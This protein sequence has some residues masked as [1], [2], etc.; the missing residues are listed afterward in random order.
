MKIFAFAGS[1]SKASI[2]KQLVE[3]T[4]TLLKEHDIEFI[5]INDFEMP[6][7]SIDKEN[8]NGIPPEAFAFSKHIEQADL[9]VMSLAEHNGAYSAAF[10]NIF[11][12]V[13][14]IPNKSVFQDKAIFL[15]ATSP[16]TRGGS[17]VLEIAKNRFPFNGGNVVDTFSLPSFSET[18]EVGKGIVNETLLEE[19]VNKINKVVQNQN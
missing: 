8:E 12:W 1:N 19:L 6:I 4:L 9:I 5:D 14:R 13:S 16:G 18:F 15:M 17:N 3:F 11:D 10:K 2:N 7:F